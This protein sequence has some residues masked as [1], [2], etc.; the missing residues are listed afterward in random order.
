ML[1]LI[2]DRVSGEICAGFLL[3]GDCGAFKEF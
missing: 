1:K 2:I 3:M